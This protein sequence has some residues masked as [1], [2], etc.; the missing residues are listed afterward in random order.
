M[1]CRRQIH[2]PGIQQEPSRKFDETPELAGLP[3][4][5]GE[6]WGGVFWQLRSALRRDLADRLLAKAWQSMTWPIAER[7]TARKFIDAV[8]SNAKDMASDQQVAEI[9]TTFRKRAFP[10]SD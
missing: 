4:D 1:V 5:R 9:K 2:D 6:I 10:T 8:L 7:D 3:Q